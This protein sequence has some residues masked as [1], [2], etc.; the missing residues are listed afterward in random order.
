MDVVV[1][2]VVREGRILVERRSPTD[3][4]SPGAVRFP[5]G[6]VEAGESLEEALRREVKE[7]LGRGVSSCRKVREADFEGKDGVS[8][9]LHYFLVTLD[10]PPPEGEPWRWFD[11]GQGEAMD[12]PADREL[13]RELL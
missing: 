1:A 11:R 10:G 7:E 2:L 4:H 9:R 3:P 5:A 12:F 8:R 13:I 6:H